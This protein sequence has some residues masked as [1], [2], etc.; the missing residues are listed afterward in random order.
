MAS[1][2]VII[3]FFL[4]FP[5]ICTSCQVCF[6]PYHLI[7]S[8][9]NHHH[10]HHAAITS[11]SSAIT[12]SP[13]VTTAVAIAVA[14]RR[15]TA[16]DPSFILQQF[17]MSLKEKILLNPTTKSK[18]IGTSATVAIAVGGIAI[19]HRM[20]TES[21]TGR[22]FGISLR[23]N[24]ENSKKENSKDMD[25][26]VPSGKDTVKADD[27]N[28]VSS[29]MIATIGIYKNFISPLLPPACRFV[30]TCSQY[31]VQAIQ[32]FGPTKG[33]ILISW[34]LLRCSPIG[35]KGYDPP[36]WPPVPFTYSSY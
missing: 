36:K 18:L 17:L 25:D 11:S 10:H 32:E 2:H 21:T 8:P 22:K 33:V 31:G 28:N 4:L 1:V 34:R 16:N 14:Q 6:S 23:S 26:K 13:K 20:T 12:N 29:A 19:A 24:D 9:Q 15:M 5:N 30:P 35:G 27:E 3:A 7:H